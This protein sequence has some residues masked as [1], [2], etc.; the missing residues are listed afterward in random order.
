MLVENADFHF[1]NDLPDDLKRAIDS[2]ISDDWPQ[3][4]SATGQTSREPRPKEMESTMAW[5]GVIHNVDSHEL[6]YL[7]N[8][9]GEW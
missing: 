5:S 8:D 3:R 4:K 1:Y 2:K 7:Y 6:V 9:L